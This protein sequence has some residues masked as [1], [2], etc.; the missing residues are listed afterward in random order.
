M[1]RRAFESYRNQRPLAH[2]GGRS[3]ASPIHHHVIIA[4]RANSWLSLNVQLPIEN[5]VLHIPNALSYLV[6]SVPNC[7]SQNNVMRKL[8]A[9]LGHA[10]NVHCA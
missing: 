8:G 4:R 2:N 1:P 7:M 10:P 6:H 9:A 5:V 3:V